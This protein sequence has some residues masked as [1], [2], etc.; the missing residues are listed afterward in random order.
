MTGLSELDAKWQD[1][2]LGLI[3]ERD[4]KD[5]KVQE[6]TEE[7]LRLFEKLN[8]IQEGLKLRSKNYC[9]WCFKFWPNS[10]EGFQQFRDHIKECIEHPLQEAYRVK[11]NTQQFA[12]RIARQRNELREEVAKSDYEKLISIIKGKVDNETDIGEEAV[13]YYKG[14]NNQTECVLEISGEDKSI[15]LFDSKGNLLTIL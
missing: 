9:T 6:L 12:L 7:N 11:Y 13:Q 3:R 5:Q 8:N 10:K 15:W 14:T 2:I 1:I 4:T